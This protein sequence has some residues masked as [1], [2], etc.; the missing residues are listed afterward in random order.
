MKITIS[1]Q[2]LTE[3]LTKANP[4]AAPSKVSTVYI[5]DKW[6]KKVKNKY[7]KTGK[8]YSKEEMLQF[9]IMQENPDI[10]PITKIKQIRNQNNELEPLI[11]QQKINVSKQQGIYFSIQENMG[12]FMY[13]R[14]ILETIAN[15]GM[16]EY[17][18]SLI[19][20]IMGRLSERLANYFKQYILLSQRLYEI[21]K[22][23]DLKYSADLHSANF[24]LDGE[25]I[26]VVDFLSPFLKI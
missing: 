13:F 19:A 10:F 20:N 8:K 14:Q 17:M 4:T 2:I 7:E 12:E 24:G 9:Q 25:K 1:E 18:K 23:Y 15:E 22:K 5:G 11:L 21:R 6:V 26:K 16:N 3:L